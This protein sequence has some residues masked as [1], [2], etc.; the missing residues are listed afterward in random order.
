MRNEKRSFFEIDMQKLM[1][2]YLEKWWLLLLGAVLAMALSLLYTV[3]FITPMYTASVTVYVNSTKTAG[4][5]VMFISSST[6]TAA[7]R[8]VNTYMKIIESD[9]VLTKVAEASKLDISSGDIGRA[10]SAEQVGNTELFKVRISHR[11]PKLAAQIA[12]AVAEVAPG[13]IEKVVEGSST[14]IID[15]A[16]VPSVPSSPNV[17]KNCLLG[18]VIG[19][20]LVL[21]YLTVCFRLDVRIK[22]E[23][24]LASLFDAP[25]LGQIPVFSHDNGK[26]YGAE[27][28]AYDTSADQQKGDAT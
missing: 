1:L 25:V 7:Q 11:D 23:D 15:F 24:E 14:K 9:S 16:K 6:I 2:T 17:R 19:F 28:N 3:R 20:V 13:E 8:L 26:R 10:M 21:I 12:N 4:E 22:D 18:G 5:E 27:G